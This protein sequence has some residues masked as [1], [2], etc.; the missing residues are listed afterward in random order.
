MNGSCAFFL[1]YLLRSF[2]LFALYKNFIRQI[3]I[4]TEQS[5][6]KAVEKVTKNSFSKSEEILDT[7][8][9]F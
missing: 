5:S 7:Y 1:W 2:D 6:T 9:I 8:T 4:I 3:K